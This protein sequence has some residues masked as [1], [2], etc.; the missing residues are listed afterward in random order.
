MTGFP[1]QGPELT[2]DEL[3]E[4]ADY[5]TG[6]LT[7]GQADRV[8]QL[9][10]I[11]NRWAAAHTALSAAE[12][13]L[14]TALRSAAESPPEMPDDLAARLDTMFATPAPDRGPAPRRRRPATGSRPAPRASTHTG[15]GGSR[16]RSRRPVLARIA[17][18]VLIVV[19]VG[20]VTTVARGLLTQSMPGMSAADAPADEAEGAG[21]VSAPS[22]APPMVGAPEASVDQLAGIPL[23]ATGI[24]YRQDTLAQLATDPL[25]MPSTL[26]T[27]D[28]E[29]RAEA[30]LFSLTGP[31]RLAQCLAAVGVAYP[32]PVVAV[33]FARF[34]GVPAAILVVRQP[35]SSTV[36]AVGPDCGIS[37][38]DILASVEVP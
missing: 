26:D 28:T 16:A 20:G 15:P 31:D 12:P 30:E 19:A 10:R 17:A 25:P 23:L 4:L 8:A 5:A 3:D 14:R 1:I 24:D 35:D 27:R 37:G 33:D 32:G 18:A 6:A 29:F 2:W 34:E 22:A 13:V 11:D 9:I 36:V 38:A 7:G 21:V